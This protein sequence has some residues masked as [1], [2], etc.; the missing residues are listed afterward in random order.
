MSATLSGES[1]MPWERPPTLSSDPPTASEWP[2]AVV[3]RAADTVGTAAD[4]VG[5]AA[6]GV[7]T[8]AKERRERKRAAAFAGGVEAIS[9]WSSASG[10]AGVIAKSGAARTPPDRR[11]N[12]R[13]IPEGCG[14]VRRTG[15]GM[16]PHPSGVR[17]SFVTVSGGVA[18]PRF[19]RRLRHGARRSPPAILPD[20]SGVATEPY[21]QRRG[22]RVNR[23]RRRSFSPSARPR[24]TA[25]RSANRRTGG[26]LAPRPSLPIRELERP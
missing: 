5:G 7:G 21:P 8:G 11:H 17:I 22:W 10:H 12:K 14:I 18:P 2:A 20:A 9:R 25:S 4:I 26:R 1:P 3:G 24:S 13:R 15:G 16:P 23:P 19:W 6:D